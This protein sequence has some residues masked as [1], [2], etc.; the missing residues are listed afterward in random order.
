MSDPSPS[1]WEDLVRHVEPLEDIPLDAALVSTLEADNEPRFR[2]HGHPVDLYT[3]TFKSYQTSEI[4]SCGKNAWPAVSITGPDCKLRCDHC[5]AKLL[6]PMIPAR[7]PETLW[8]VVNGIVEQGGEGMLLTGGSNHRNEVEYGPFYDTI[9]RIKDSFPGFRIALH[10][11]L[12][13]DDAARCMEQAG[14]DA[15]MMDVIGAQETITQVYHLK[16]SVADFEATLEALVNTRMKVV[17]HI[18]MGLHYG[19]FLGE[20]EALNMI[21]RHRPDA[22]VLVVVMPFYAPDSKPFATPQAV[23]VGHFFRDARQALP[24]LP[25]LLGCA[26][27]A[28]QVK[29]EMDAYAVM[30][31]IDGLAHPADGVVE[32]A[33]RLGRQVR[34]IPSCCSMAVGEEVMA[35]D[36]GREALE[37]D[38]EAIVAD[39]RARRRQRGAPGM[40]PGGI[41]VVMENVAPG[42]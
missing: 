27:P 21:Q 36:G 29:G 32:L 13:D 11:A 35:L 23:D 40:G 38:L 42:A 9:R 14:I 31:G 2:N 3:P 41:P 18:V 34:V 1:H 6:E 4:S 8:R 24:D 33:A 10:T 12:V 25:L 5:K 16:R 22:V 39:E 15:A 20:W 26:R 19:R 7:D 17:P 28:G 37:I 30:A